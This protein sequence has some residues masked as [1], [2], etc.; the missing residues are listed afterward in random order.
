MLVSDHLRKAAREVGVNPPA[1][2]FGFHTFRRTLA[3][4][5]I[6][7]NYDPKLVQELLRQ[8]NVKTTL[9]FYASA[10]TPAKLEAQGWFLNKLLE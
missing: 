8:A 3:S 10:V 1:R 5:L 2:V 4:V 6:G 7:N 9:D